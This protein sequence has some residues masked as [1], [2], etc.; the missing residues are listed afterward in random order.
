[1]KRILFVGA[2]ALTF[3]ACKND[4]KTTAD[5]SKSDVK[6][7]IKPIEGAPK[8]AFYVL[9]SVAETFEVYKKETA[10]FEKEGLALQNQLTSMQK[11]Y[12]RLYTAYETGAR[13]QTLTPNQAASYEQNI[14]AIQQKMA[15]FQQDKMAKFQQRQ[16]DA[17]TA[18]QNK[19]SMY[20]KEFSE[21]NGIDMFFMGGTGSPLVFGNP[22]LDVTKEFVDYMN[23][24]EEKK[25]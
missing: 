3:A 23:A 4:K 10:I 16:M 2:L 9:D 7:E 14:G 22:A 25:N 11:E 18:I 13:Q 19:I 5:A 1:M 20:S 21:A 8:M 6:R 24:E 15:V 12:E 17:T